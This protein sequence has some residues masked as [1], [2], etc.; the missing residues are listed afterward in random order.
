MIS[1]RFLGAS[2]NVT[3]SRHLLSHGEEKVLVDCG[4][5]QEHNL[6]YRNWDPFPV[7]PAEIS[8]VF[9]THA[10]LDHSGFLPCLVKQG[11]RGKIFATKPTIEVTKIALLDA[12]HIYEE[13]IEKKRIRHAQENRIVGHPDIP[14]YT[15]D[16][17]YRVF[18]M[19]EEVPYSEPV[20][21]NKHFSVTYHNAGHIIGSAMIE[22]KDVAS[23]ENIVFSGDLGRPNKPLLA[24]PERF[25]KIDWL[26]LESTYGDRNHP[27]DEEIE[28]VFSQVINDT[29]QNGGNIVIPS[30]AIER[31]QEVLYC[32]RKLLDKNQIP[33]LLV[34]LDS[35]M[36]IRVTEI[37]RQYPS[38]LREGM[39]ELLKNSSPFD[40]PLLKITRTPDESKGINHL[41]GTVIIIAGS[42][43][44][45]GGRIK[46][47][48]T[49]NIERGESTILFVGYQA[50]GTLGR[51]IVDGAREVR[52]L[53]RMYH[54]NAHIEQIQGFSSH[55][56]QSEIINWLSSLSKTPERIF[57]VHGEDN[58]LNVLSEKIRETFKFPVEIG[59]YNKET[60]LN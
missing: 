30:F 17:A 29:K 39:A 36:A 58:A 27:G 48:L 35:P 11:F 40:F 21:L 53:G 16:D 32:L 56:D 50:N 42:G 14:L 7:R 54:V 37:F 55:A 41:R 45:N 24:D 46:H 47:H 6:L 44:C 22:F 18:D 19:F 60:V 10:H 31:T 38:F 5:Y 57:L 4:I 43:M 33:H 25:E 2:R 13:D 51:E 26:V 20:T 49:K 15:V 59:E 52:I 34:F 1:L 12:A 3:G 9:L 8:S 23:G 28:T